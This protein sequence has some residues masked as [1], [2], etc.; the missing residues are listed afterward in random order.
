[1]EPVAPAREALSVPLHEARIAEA[2]VPP[3]E[4]P[5]AS[6]PAHAPASPNPL[7]AW[8][9]SGNVLTRIGVVALFFG[10][11]FLL[12]YLAEIVTVSI[13]VKLFAVAIV[14]AALV[15]VG[16]RLARSR[17]GYGL[18]LEGAGA[19]VLYLTTFAAFRL[20]DVLPATAAFVLLVA[21][22]ALTV[23][24]AVR[25]DSQPLAALAVAGGFLAPFLVATTPGEPAML[26]GYFLVL[27]AAILAL[28]LVRAWRAL[29]VLGFVFTFV[30]AVF[31]GERYYRPEHFATVEPFLAVFFAFYVAIAVLYAK[32]GALVAKAPVDGILVFGVP[33]VALALQAAIVHDTRY[34]VAYSALAM[35]AVY[36]ALWFALHRRPEP[37]LVLLSK[38]F[39]ALAVV[40]ATIAVPF[41]ADPQWTSAWWALESA[42]V[43]WIGCRQKQVIARGFA[44]LLQVGAALAF[45]N[46]D[47]DAGG[48]MFL[49]ATF[50]GSVLVA[51]AAFATAFVAERHRDDITKF[52]RTLMPFLMVWGT[53]WWYGA[54]ANELGREVP[55]AIQGN[56]IL[57][58]VVAS[59]VAALA[60]RGPLRWPQLAWVGAGLL[61]MMALVALYDWDRQRSTLIAYGWAVWPLAWIVHWRMLRA[62]DGLREGAAR[63][64]RIASFLRFSHAASAIALVAWSAWEASEWVGRL[65]PIGTV[66][67]ACAAA[68]PAIAYLLG[69]TACRTSGA[70]PMREYGEA[71]AR[72]AGTAIA[73]LLGA[74]FCIVNVISPGSAAP[75]P[76]VPLLNPLDLT[77]VLA[78]T[79]IFVW[80]QRTQQVEERTLYAWFGIALFVFVNAIVFRSVHHWLGVPWRTGALFASKPLQAALTLTWTATALPLMLIATRR[81]IRPL[82]MTGA[83]LL[84]VVV[85]KLFAVDLSSLAGLPRI[86]AFL[87]VGALL[88][89]IGYLAPLPP[90]RADEPR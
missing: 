20:Y 84:A 47:F 50:F 59:V 80:A 35:A 17:P 5:R 70:W 54:G 75:L 71:Y 63:P 34:G 65:F 76:Y 7:W 30:L 78:L 42:A 72:T 68:L 19:G 40:L 1:M 15:L 69:V 9:T 25:E 48:R 3:V 22:A 12:K 37:G 14:G 52:E 51:L 53:L 39:F 60:L 73:A 43:Y 66:W 11:G 61:P 13:E 32:R 46:G 24:M 31:W 23:W 16:A 89:V 6:V 2:S 27:N 77:L 8:F 82:W 85:V 79:A 38:A 58:Y 57:G 21:I 62:A 88:L 90:A 74:W 36:A 55:D 64:E 18:S 49:N 44:L 45:A 86:V 26:F 33:M 81:A 28:A 83:A 4:P 29:N 41:A 10:I 67:V 87:G 56:A